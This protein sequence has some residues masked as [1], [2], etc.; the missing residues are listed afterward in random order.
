[1]PF[2]KEKY[3]LGIFRSAVGKTYRSHP[4]DCASCGGGAHPSWKKKKKN[5]FS[6]KKFFF[7]LKKKK[8]NFF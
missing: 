5:F 7:F 3:L 4:P 1:M 2:L 8:K 6:K